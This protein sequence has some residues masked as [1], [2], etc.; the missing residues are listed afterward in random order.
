MALG[1]GADTSFLAERARGN[2]VFF[3]SV[4]TVGGDLVFSPGGVLIREHGV[5]V[6]AVGVSGDTG[7]MDAQCAARASPPPVLERMMMK[8][9]S[10]ELAL[11]KAADAHQWMIDIWGCAD[12][13]AW[14]HALPARIGYLPLSGGFERECG[15]LRALHH[16]V[17]SAE[18][19]ASI[20][21][22]RRR[23]E[24]ERPPVVSHD[25]GGG[26]GSWSNW[27]RANCCAS[28]W[29]PPKSSRWTATPPMPCAMPVKL[30]HVVFNAAD[31]EASGHLS[32]SA[33]LPR[34]GPHQGHGLR[35]LQRC[36]SFHRLCPR[37]VC[38]PE[39]HRL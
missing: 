15:P 25:P 33:G 13:G 12:A 17:C 2:P 34:V 23:R 39:P 5:I 11:P 28:W 36:A 3:R 9:R 27:P 18:R 8:L 21:Q 30:T 10:I 1:M 19:L 32:R 38:Q 22:G 20:A 6:G 24:P 29:A 14:R 37:R 31:A 7:E 26:E 16:L 4:T 35:A